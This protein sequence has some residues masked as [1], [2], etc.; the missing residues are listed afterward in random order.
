MSQAPFEQA[1][2]LRIGTVDFVSPDEIKVALDIEAPETVALNA[3]TPRPFPRVNGYLLIPVDEG[4]LVGQV[5]WV[6]VERSAFPKRRGMQDFGLVDLPYPLRR[7]SLNPLGTLRMRSE[8]TRYIFRRGADALP[9]VGTAVVLPTELQ[10]R[11]IVESGQRR[12]VKIGTS[13]LAGDAVVCVDPNRL[14][15]RHLAVLGNTGSGKSCSVAGL[16][17]WSLEEA[18]VARS[19]QPNARF[20]VLDPNGEYSR[21]FGSGDL[22]VRGRIFK[23]NPAAGE[24]AL[25]VPLWFWNS[26]EWCSFTQASA[27]TQRP[28]LRRALREV[29]AGRTE[30][31]EPSEEEKKL[32][33]RRRLSS[34]LITLRRDLRSSAVKTEA[35]RFGF[36]LEA[37]LCDLESWIPDFPG[38]PLTTT[39]DAIKS[40]LHARRKDGVDRTSGKPFV[41][42]VAFTDAEVRTIVSSVETALTTLGGIVYQEGPDEDVPLSFSGTDLADHLE[43]LAEQETVSQFLDFLIARIRT[44]L[45]DAKMKSVIGDIDGITLEQWLKDYIGSDKAIEG[46]VSV[47]DLSLVPTEVVHVVTAVIARMVFE[48]LQRYV[49]LNGVALPTVVVM[50]EAHTFI[51][52]YKEDIENQDAATVCCQVFERIA[53]EGRKFGLGLVLSSQRPSELSPTVLSQCNTFLLHRISND[54]DQ[55]LV[56]RLVPDNLKGLLRELPSLPSQSAILLGWASELPVLLKMNDLPKTQQPRSEDPDFWDV[57]VGQNEKGEPVSRNIDWKR[58]VGDW[59]AGPPAESGGAA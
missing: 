40:A 56:H 11:S 25:K 36:Q 18:Q 30:I 5:E 45:S 42:F 22:T 52:R 27:K 35:T 47:I 8:D 17:R 53:R 9:S 7:L 43:I 10:L 2:S 14:F 46:C 12:R 44:F 1:G 26:A 29:K 20:I 33:L 28:L 54:R 23:V 59:Q 48:A 24:V 13:P 3:G 37:I 58:I 19:G 57:W 49:K 51:K 50:D 38:C 15:G 31:T 39:R 16:I 6:T 4:F 21:A 34:T 41:Y 55:E 32:V